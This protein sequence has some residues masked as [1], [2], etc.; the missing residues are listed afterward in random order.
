MSQAEASD[1]TSSCSAD[2]GGTT[3]ATEVSSSVAGDEFVTA[4][5]ASI[6]NSSLGGEYM[7]AGMSEEQIQAAIETSEVQGWSELKQR[8][9]DGAAPSEHAQENRVIWEQLKEQ[10]PRVFKGFGEGRILKLGQRIAEGGQAHIYEATIHDLKGD[11]PDYNC[12]AK[13]FKMEGFSLAYLQREWPLAIKRPFNERS[14]LEEKRNFVEGGV[15]F[16]EMLLYCGLIHYG[17]FLENGRFAFVM[18]R[19][20][21]DLRTLINLKIKDSN[22]QGPPF[23]HLD[24]MRIMYEISVGVEELHDRGVLHRDLKA[25]NVLVTYWSERSIIMDACVADYESAMLVQ[26]TGFWRAP[27]VLEQL[28]KRPCDWNVNIWTEKVDVYS[29]AMTCY[30]VLTGHVPFDGYGKSD[31]KRVIDGERPHLPDYIDVRTRELVERCWHKEPAER[32]TFGYITGELQ[33]LRL[34]AEV[35]KHGEYA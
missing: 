12:V 23:S 34:C 13:V 22:Y 1:I 18:K 33:Y 15:V 7:T 6:L 20:W 14:K 26:G 31:W 10:D 17:T 29:F 27:E 24:T 28:L 30:E 25:A 21:G 4:S 32:P 8:S 5:S 3:P 2:A 11:L 19:Y 35:Y 9:D 16:G